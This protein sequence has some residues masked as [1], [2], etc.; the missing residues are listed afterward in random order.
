MSNRVEQ[1]SAAPVPDGATTAASAARLVAAV[2]TRMAG[3]NF[4][5][6]LLEHGRTVR[7]EV[8]TIEEEF[9]SDREV[10]I[11]VWRHLDPLRAVERAEACLGQACRIHFGTLEGGK[12]DHGAAVRGAAL[13]FD[14]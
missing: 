11:G 3:V 10:G 6:G 9:G 7:A 4:P 8:G 1:A 5:P 2:D 14:E 12:L 13:C